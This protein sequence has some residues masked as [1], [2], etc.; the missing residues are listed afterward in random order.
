MYHPL[1]RP[2]PT[3]VSEPD[4]CYTSL[5]DNL[6]PQLVERRETLRQ[7]F[8]TAPPFPHIVLDD[9]LTDDLYQR[10]SDEF[11][12]AREDAAAGD[13]GTTGRKFTRPDITSI[14]SAYREFDALI[15]SAE[16][17]AW[18]GHITGVPGLLYDPE[19]VGGGTHENLSGQD[20]DPHIDFN[21]HPHTLWHRRLNL[22]YFLNDEWD[23]H[24]GGLIEFHRNPWDP[25]LNTIERVLPIRNRAVIFETS[26]VSWH[27]FE[28]IQFPPEKQHLSRRSLAAYFYTKNRPAEQTAAEHATVYVQRPLPR[29]IKPGHTLTEEDVTV[30]ETLIVRR[31]QQIRY[32]YQREK[33]LLRIANRFLRSP[34]VKVW[35]RLKKL[36]RRTPGSG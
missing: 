32:L 11:P 27:G 16:F 30:V 2:R 35:A 10:L 6:N 21:Y 23:A 26:E 9:F 22:I 7:T 14:G 20:L 24:W 8:T 29:H 34:A 15:R 36:T 3:F 12:A 19:Y 13:Y 18:L 33:E 31:D 28:R 17:L 4:D 5:I 25:E 1:P